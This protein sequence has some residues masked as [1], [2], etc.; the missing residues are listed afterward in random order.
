[1]SDI[2]E[3]EIGEM[4]VLLSMS[5]RKSVE[6]VESEIDGGMLGQTIGQLEDKVYTMGIT[7]QKVLKNSLKFCTRIEMEELFRTYHRQSKAQVSSQVSKLS[8][9]DVYEKQQEFEHRLNGL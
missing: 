1:M 9:D 5:T 3:A 2:I 4:G 8:T 7:V 6:E